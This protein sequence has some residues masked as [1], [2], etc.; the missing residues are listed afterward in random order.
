MRC[1][2]EDF[3]GDPNIVEVYVVAPA[4]QARRAVRPAQLSRPCAARATGSG[5]TGREARP[6]RRPSLPSAHH[7]RCPHRRGPLVLRGRAAGDRASSNGQMVAQIDT[8]LRRRRRLHRPA[9]SPAASG[10]PI[11]EGPTDLYVQFVASDGAASSAPADRRPGPAPPS[12]ARDHRP[13]RIAARHDPVLGDLRVLDVPRSGHPDVTLVLARSSAGVATVRAPPGAPAVAV[14]G[15]PVGIVAGRPALWLVVGR[16]LRPVDRM[17]RTVDAI[18]D[19]RPEP[20][21]AGR[22]ARATSSTAWPTR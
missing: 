4:P 11:D 13:G 19:R 6:S 7:R 16:A 18:G 20:P 3:T 15:P 10:L 14:A 8:A 5:T 1:G 12:P 2:A 21:R 9:S 17:R 22:P